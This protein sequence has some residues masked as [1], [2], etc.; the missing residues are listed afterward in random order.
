MQ[1]EYMSKI[2]LTLFFIGKQICRG[3]GKAEEAFYFIFIL[4]LP[5]G[6]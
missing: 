4:V 2:L 3:R 5:Q 1:R 6:V